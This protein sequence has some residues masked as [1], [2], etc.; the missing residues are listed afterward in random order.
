MAV[1]PSTRRGRFIMSER[2]SRT[3][4]APPLGPQQFQ[5]QIER[6][7]FLIET[8]LD[9]TAGSSGPATA[10]DQ[11]RLV[12]QRFFDGER[13]EAVHAPARVPAFEIE[14]IGLYDNADHC[15]R[16]W[17]SIKIWVAL[18]QA[19]NDGPV[20]S[21]DLGSR[22]TYFC[23]VSINIASRARSKAS[24]TCSACRHGGIDLEFD[25]S[26]AVPGPWEVS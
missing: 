21:T 4:A 15:C 23:P 8:I 6:F 18:K 24:W 25:R 17:I 26:R 10:S 20:I 22:P 1:A 7:V 5:E 13:I 11:A 14:A 12:E 19:A 9:H 16:R 2:R 3:I